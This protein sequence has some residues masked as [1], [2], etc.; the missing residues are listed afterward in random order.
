MAVDLGAKIK[1]KTYRFELKKKFQYVAHYRAKEVP[2]I[3]RIQDAL[4]KML[5]PKP[6]EKKAAELPTYSQP[7]GGFNFM[8]FGAFLLIALII[9]VL[10]WLYLTT[11]VLQPSGA[12]FQS[13]EKPDISNKILGGEILTSGDRG[14][15]QHVAG[16]MVAYNTSNL[17]NYTINITTYDEKIPSEVFILNSE[18]VEA[19]TYPDFL[20]LLRSDLAK[21]KVILNEITLKQLQTIPQGAIVIVPSGTIPKE[22]IGI[23][24][25]LSMD[26]LAN[27]GVVVVYVGQPFT[28]MLNGSTTVFTPKSVLNALPVR[29]DQGTPLE[30]T[31]NFSL[32]QPLYR[33]TSA[34]TGWSGNLV[35]GS[36]S[37]L[38]KGDGAFVFLPQTL[39]GGWRSNSTSAADDISRIVF[40][41]PWA[42][43]NAPPA[44]YQL[45]NQSS[46][47]GTRFFFSNAFDSSNATVRVDFIGY[48][49]TSNYPV[50]QTLLTRLEQPSANGLFIEGGS[51]VVPTN[52]TNQ[53]IRL[54]AHL[55]EAVAAQPSMSLIITDV[56]GT[57]VQTF[58]Q[59][60]VN[61][62][63]DRSF[64]ILLYVN[65]GEYL[66][67]LADD[68][69]KV[70]AESY[71]KVVSIDINYTGND[72]QRHSI[73][74]FSITMDGN[75]KTLTDVSVK[76]DNGT[77]GTYTYQ[78]V[79]K[80]R[81]DVGQFTGGE[82]LPVGKHTFTF[83]AGGLTEDLPLDTAKPPTI[84][85]NPLFIIV[86]VLTG[87]IVGIGAIFARQEQVFFA[88]DIP[89]FPP[90]ARTRI[91]LS[92][93]VV[94]SIFEKVNENYRWQNTPLTPPE[95]K[96]G[97][98]D[99]FIHGKPIY[100]TDYNVEFILEELEKRG[101]LKESLGY[102]GLMD[103]EQKSGHSMEYL[104]LLRRV[105][106]ICV[107]N[108]I[109]FTGIGESKDADTNITVVGQQM[110]VHFYERGMDLSRLFKRVLPTIGH[111]IAIV[112]LK[113]VADKDYLMS[114]LNSSPTVAP[115]IVKMEADSSSLLF[116]TTDELEKM[117]LEF[118]SM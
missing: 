79:D 106:D 101:K 62:Q 54:N 42:E 35:Y 92:P 27:R 8:V 47:D 83:T 86:I 20:R 52:I 40:E 108:A 43:P 14:S 7:K 29:F 57:D 102:F 11:Q 50:R 12:A 48:A 73:Y 66:V 65:P 80:L 110:A 97:F 88:L 5:A 90:V 103:W 33:A 116:L 104:A 37:V 115:L 31:D 84:F 95:I 15:P 87:G 60:N 100:I 114:V 67:K 53:P 10:G 3:K 105:R 70:Y 94:L 24:S 55:Q 63:A 76:V 39:D 46:Y 89:D 19:V 91:P 112:L 44:T 98:K 22:L 109:P 26:A 56:N 96:N 74:T 117:L 21:R 34:G 2:P 59:G 71:M 16:V 51:H 85:D 23:D 36:V 61:V 13:V 77:M 49:N 111:G 25:Q 1:K 68:Q 30:S 9:I 93:D 99:I 58:P 4:K 107:N 118:K 45:T 113:N 75:P 82:F 41:S 38:K 17:N 18:R 28:Q 6:V 32:F 72:P 78:N 69:S 64:D 81:V